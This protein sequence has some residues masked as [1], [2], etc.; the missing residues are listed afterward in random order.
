MKQLR[1]EYLWGRVMALWYWL[2]VVTEGKRAKD[3]VLLLPNS[4]LRVLLFGITSGAS[5]LSCII[6]ELLG[7][8]AQEIVLENSLGIFK[9]RKGS[10]DVM[11]VAEANEREFTEYLLGKNP[12]V[13]LD[14]G[15]NI[16]RYTIPMARRSGQVVAF[17][18]DPD[19]FKA[20]QENI[21]LNN[22]GSNC[23]AMVRVTALEIG[24]WHEEC[25]V[26]MNVAPI[27]KKGMSSL[28][29]GANG[30]EV[31][32]KCDTIDNM[33]KRLGIKSVDLVKMDIEGAEKEAILGMKETIANSPEIEILFEAFNRQYVR[34][35]ADALKQ[36]GIMNEP[37][38]MADN[39]YK[40]SK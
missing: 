36:V 26:S 5:F 1:P 22:R 23:P 21:S 4:M 16:G 9:C 2:K 30:K 18:C 12:K 13:F 39:M 24:C 20:L 34:E 35:C 37:V 7:K 19:N 8:S 29:V 27:D 14:V 38:E 15:A 31:M 33:L 40:V 28:K 25:E 32:V 10:N 3:K 11:I 17:D 6:N